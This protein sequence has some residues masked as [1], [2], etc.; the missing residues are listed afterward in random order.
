MTTLNEVVASNESDVVDLTQSDDF[1]D[2]LKTRYHNWLVYYPRRVNCEWGFYRL[3]DERLTVEAASKLEEYR[4]QC[5]V[6]ETKT[7]SD[8]K[9]KGSINW[10]KKNGTKGITSH[11]TVHHGE[12]YAQLKDL[13]RYKK[14]KKRRVDLGRALVQQRVEDTLKAFGQTKYEKTHPIQVE[15]ELDVC[16]SIGRSLQPFNHTELDTYHRQWGRRDPKLTI[17]TSHTIKTILMPRLVNEIVTNYVTPLLSQSS[18]VSLSFDVWMTSQTEE[19]VSVVAHTLDEKWKLRSVYVGLLDIHSTKGKDLAVAVSR[20]IKEHNLATK[21]FGIVTD[22]GKNVLNATEILKRN[23]TCDSFLGAQPY[24]GK[25]WAH[26]LNNVLKQMLFPAKSGK[27]FDAGFKTFKWK[28]INRKLQQCVTY[29]RKS[30]K[31]YKTWAKA[32]VE[33]NLIPRKLYSPVHTRFGSLVMMHGQLLKYKEAVTRCYS[34]STEL[35]KRIPTPLEWIVVERVHELVLPVFKVCILNQ[36]SESWI[37]T[38]AI[39]VNLKVY[40]HLRSFITSLPA[41]IN[42]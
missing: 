23:A 38:D 5:V 7:N 1:L 25:C 2:G 14:N 33:A 39:R 18:A 22:D 34:V 28:D 37:V 16:L 26:L 6:C 30:S 21:I 12:T 10:S 42:G 20:V 8:K 40:R 9:V 24:H 19:I 41:I 11:V 35:A 4:L 29:T 3:M 15:F 27:K 31:G 32:C 36:T 17:P 13:I